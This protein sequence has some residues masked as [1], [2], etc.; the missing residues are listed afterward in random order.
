NVNVLR[1]SF[2]D[3]FIQHRYGFSFLSPAQPYQSA[4]DN[5]L[6]FYTEIG[7]LSWLFTG[8]ISKSIERKILEDFPNLTFDIL[9]V[10]HHGSNTSTDPSFAKKTNQVALVSVGSHNT[11]GHPTKEVIDTLHE[12]SLTIYRTDIHGAVQYRFKGEKG[13]FVPFL[14]K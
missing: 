7:G 9:K 10:A 5:S 3:K 1:V 11:Y 6:V 4:N 2:Q 13:V 14:E 8:D 12:E